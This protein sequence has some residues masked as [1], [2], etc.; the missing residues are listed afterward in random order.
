MIDIP[1]N[2]DIVLKTLTSNPLKQPMPNQ[3]DILK[4]FLK[5]LRETNLKVTVVTNGYH[6]VTRIYSNGE[7]YTLRHVLNIIY[8][9]EK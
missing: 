1:V 4:G 3:L 8:G 7:E 9:E 5:A 2:Q 6:Q